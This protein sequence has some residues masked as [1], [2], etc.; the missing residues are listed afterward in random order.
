[1]SEEH[2]DIT[3]LKGVYIQTFGCQM[4][5]YDS[6]K[7][8]EQLRA[9]NYTLVETPDKAQLILVNTCAVREKA[10]HKVY[11]LLGRLGDLKDERPEVVIGVG[12]CVAQ[13]RGKEILDRAKSVD[14]VFGTDNLFQLP[15]MLDAVARGERVLQTD[16]QNRKQKVANFIPQFEINNNG[17]LG[18]ETQNGRMFKANLAIT[19]GCNNYCTFC[20]VPYTRGLEVS[21]EPGNILEEA[22]RQVSQGAKEIMLLGQNV[23]SYKA[24]GVNFVDLLQRMNEISGLERIRYTSPHPKDFN[25]TLADAHRDLPKLCEHL[26]LPVQSGSDRILKAMRRNHKIE[27]YLEKLDMMRQKVP[28]IAISSDIIVGFPGETETDFEDTLE[29]LR[30]ARF[31]QIYAFKFSAR[32]DTP[33]AK[34]DDQVPEAVKADRLA[35]LFELYEGIVLEKN[36]TMVG[37]REEVLLE[38]KHPKVQGA[39]TGRSRGY[40]SVMVMD[41]DKQAGELE[42]VEVVSVRKFSLVARGLT[43]ESA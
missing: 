13:Q 14:L 4:N 29:V 16:W 22:T 17:S 6:T 12:G 10:E 8:V 37:K 30:K 26:H 35:R 18:G 5:E 19:K 39:M 41:C 20:V 23:N 32:S 9:S 33:A 43:H 3:N 36:Q 24:N 21:R 34:Y 42:P 40:K 28:D 11:S 25:E 27:Q 31:D 1:M 38:G 2:Q 15:E 7:M